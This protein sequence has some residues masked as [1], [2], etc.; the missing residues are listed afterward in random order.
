MNVQ[1]VDAIEN[2]IKRFPKGYVFTCNDFYAEAE[3]KDTVRKTLN[4][5]ADSGKIRKLSKGKYYKPRETEFGSLKPPVR[6]IVKDLL[7]K[8]GKLTGYLTG[9][10]IYNDLYLSTQISNTLQIGANKYKRAIKRGRYRITFVLQPNAINK[11]NVEL[12]QIL[13]CLRFIDE[14]PASTPDEACARLM[15]IISELPPEKQKR[16][17]KLSLKYTN[18]VRALCGAILEQIG[19]EQE[20][21]D[22]LRKSL[23]EITTYKVPVSENVLQMKIKWNI[24]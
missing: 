3:K 7:E 6:Q 23:T 21:I 11:N 15:Q 17:A 10:S 19:A 4:R 12:L 2:A 24:V 8:N 20:L 22:R 9:Y 1:I 14:I 13:D 5:L 16:L 18:Y